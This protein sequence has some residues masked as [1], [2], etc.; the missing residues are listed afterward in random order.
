M[1][2]PAS[3]TRQSDGPQRHLLASRLAAF[4]N[5]PKLD[6]DLG[7]GIRPSASP[8]H[9]LRAD[10]LRRAQVR[11]R[12]ATAL[13]RAVE[14]VRHPVIHGTPQAPLDREA[15]RRC[16]REIRALAT[17]VATVESP[18]TQGIAIAFEL[19]FDGGSAL[20]F[21]PD[22]PDGIEQLANTVRSAQ[23]ALRVSADFDE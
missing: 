22:T 15:V 4:V 8:A 12:I 11:R 3:L 2:L 16:Q 10:H 5:A 1:A 21:H 19:A 18:R 20:F 23:N 17:S 9:R 7:A 14:D 6:A 13:E